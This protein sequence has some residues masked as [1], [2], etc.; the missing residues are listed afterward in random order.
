MV[1]TQLRHNLIVYTTLL[2]NGYEKVAIKNTVLVTRWTYRG[3]FPGFRHRMAQWDD[4][5]L[6]YPKDTT[7][8]EQCM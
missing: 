6:Q 1:S 8:I 4:M 2:L 7:R 3:L 5:L